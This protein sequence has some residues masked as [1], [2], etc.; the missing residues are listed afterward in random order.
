VDPARR[1]QSALGL[2]LDD[3]A[4][5]VPV[6][7]E[8]HASLLFPE[9]TLRR[10]ATE[11]L[12]D[13]AARARLLNNGLF[14]VLADRLAATT[15][16]IAAVRIAEWLEQDPSLTDLVVDTAPGRSGIEIL[17]RPGALVSLVEGRLA[18]WLAHVGGAGGGAEGGPPR[19]GVSGRV[20]RSLAHLGGLETLV[21]LGQLFAAVQQ[22]FH[23]V[24]A[25]LEQAQAWLHAPAT[26]VL[27]V[28]AVRE[29]AIAGARV[30]R[31][32]LADAGLSPAAVIVNRALPPELGPELARID[33]ASTG[34]EEAAVLRYTRAYLE[35][36][37]EVARGA[38]TLAPSVIPLTAVEGLDTERRLEVLAALGRQLVDALDRQAIR[39]R[40]GLAPPVSDY[41]HG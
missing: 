7:G 40:A 18:R 4:A 1:L 20:L 19:Q 37:T 17:R 33:E 27:L 12:T 8:L 28:S 38:A 34:A 9:A 39:E 15:D 16:V 36:Q 10:W 5:R 6:P 14:R 32:A 3:S 13:E 41:Q 23:R 31:G 30:L 24:L 29:D 26:R 2:R 11:G 25:R 22:P 21:E 35:I